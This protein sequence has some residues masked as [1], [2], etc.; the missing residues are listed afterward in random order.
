[1]YTSIHKCN[2]I[3]TYYMEAFCIIKYSKYLRVGE[4][5]I[6]ERGNSALLYFVLYVKVTTDSN[7]L[8]SQF[9][10]NYLCVFPKNYQ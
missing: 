1:M 6:V 2:D 3:S 10:V 8:L 7:V 5:E 9:Y 4:G